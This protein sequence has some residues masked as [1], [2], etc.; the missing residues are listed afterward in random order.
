M[1][2]VLESRFGNVEVAC[3]CDK[4]GLDALGKVAMALDENRRVLGQLVHVNILSDERD[5]CFVSR[6]GNAC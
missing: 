4:S 3:S 1:Y 5:A 6:F 2:G